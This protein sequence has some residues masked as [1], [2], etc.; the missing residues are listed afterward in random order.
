[1]VFGM[2]VYTVRLINGA[3]QVADWKAC[4][5]KQ[6]GNVDDDD[7]KWW[8]MIVKMQVW[9]RKEAGNQRQ[10]VGRRGVRKAQMASLRG[11]C[12]LRSSWGLS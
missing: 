11:I 4:G 9:W 10:R 2:W 7:V 3:V 5:K 1:M 6:G 12:S 8:K